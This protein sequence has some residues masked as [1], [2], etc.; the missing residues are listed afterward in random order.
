MSGVSLKGSLQIGITEIPTTIPEILGAPGSIVTDLYYGGKSISK[1][2]ISKG[3][4]KMLPLALGN[5]LKGIRE[6]TEGVTTGSNAPVFHGKDP[7]VADTV[8]ALLRMLSFNPSRIAAI[9]EKQWRET[10]IEA[11]YRTMRS[12]IYARFKRFYLGDKKD[13]SKA[14]Y[15]DLI[16]E[17]REYN[18]RVKGRG[19]LA[20][21]IP[22][23]SKAT[24]KSNLR[25]AFRPSKR[26]RL[27]NLKEN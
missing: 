1:G 23:I 9:R 16:A 27:R 3:F 10:M 13:R 8:D 14:K 5:I 2:D 21:G 17:V 20:K 15:I 24:L 19:L 11:K 6:G 18:T 25:R 7:L 4:E 12:E 26:E 22:L